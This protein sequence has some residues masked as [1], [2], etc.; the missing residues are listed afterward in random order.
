MSDKVIDSG[1]KSLPDLL[2]R[3][4]KNIGRG[5]CEERPRWFFV[6]KIFAVGSTTAYSLCRSLDVDPEEVVG[7]FECSAREELDRIAEIEAFESEA[8]RLWTDSDSEPPK[9][10]FVEA[11]RV[12]VAKEP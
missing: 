9:A 10:K 3:A 8:A 12:M 4:M 11:G 6:S 5:S 2:R 1:G 7:G